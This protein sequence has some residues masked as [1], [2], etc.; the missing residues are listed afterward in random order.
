MTLQGPDGKTYQWTKTTPPTRADVEALQA[1]VTPGGDSPVAVAADPSGGFGGALGSVIGDHPEIAG[2]LGGVLA[3][4]GTEAGLASGGQMLGA[5]TGPAAPIAVPIM[6]SV[7][8]GLGNYLA[9]QRRIK[10]GEQQN[11]KPGQMWGAATAGLIPG[12]S[13]AKAGPMRIGAEGVKLGFGNIAAKAVETKIDEG[14]LPNLS[15]VSLAG[16]SG[17][18]AAPLMKSMDSGA[19][20]ITQAAERKAAQD[21]YRRET[22]KFGRD[23]GYVIPPSLLNPTVSNNT[24]NSIGGKAATAQEVVIRNQAQTDAAI[25]AELALPENTAL[26]PQA[27][28]AARVKPNLVYDQLS[29]VT[30]KSGALLEQFKQAQSEG[31]SLAATYRGMFP[32]DPAV[33]DAAKSK[34]SDAQAALTNLE[35]EA[36]SVGKASLFDQFKDARLQLAKIGLVERAMN[37]GSG[38]IDGAVI[39]QA[40]DN[41][42]KL[43]GNLEKIG[44]FHQAFDKLIKDASGAPPSG[45]N[46]MLPYMAGAGALA[47]LQ[48]FGPKGLLVGAAGMMAPPMARSSM[49]SPYFQRNFVNPAYGATRPDFAALL[50]KFSAQQAGRRED[51]A[52]GVTALAKSLGSK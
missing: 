37:K 8:A 12:A 27:L 3:D 19:N 38:H 24:L 15:E 26:S 49:L 9:Q 41:G 10:M 52:S 7:G 51:A 28:N 22:I 44:R 13:L 48:Q 16:T 23:L 31:N 34:F 30:P 17:A 20:A 14:R 42:E 25:R 6:G 43:T 1:H 46:Q 32:K 39:G 18:L 33:L 4:M 45:V 35:S 47:G 21:A 11:F 36:G 29:Q 2:K 5:L 50:A 40:L